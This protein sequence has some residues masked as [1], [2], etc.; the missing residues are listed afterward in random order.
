[1]PHSAASFRPATPFYVATVYTSAWCLQ[2]KNGG[3]LR[4]IAAVESFAQDRTPDINA[5]ADPRV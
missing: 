4:F 3:G 2:G 5:R 1:M